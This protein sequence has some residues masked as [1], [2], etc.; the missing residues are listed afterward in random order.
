MHFL[1]EKQS[2]WYLVL[3]VV[4]LLL[5]QYDH[6]CP[7]TDS[8]RVEAEY[9]D[10]LRTRTYFRELESGIVGEFPLPGDKAKTCHWLMSTT[11]PVYPTEDVT[12]KLSMPV[13]S[14]YPKNMELDLKITIEN[15]D[16]TILSCFQVLA[17]TV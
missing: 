14:I 9:G 15:E 4:S 11:C 17:T 6:S 7:L 5:N 16:K 1:E 12:Y 3:Q 10:T 13:L 2:K 8:F